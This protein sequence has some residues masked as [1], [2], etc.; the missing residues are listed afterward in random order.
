MLRRKERLMYEELTELENEIIKAIDKVRANRDVPVAVVVGVL[1]T[2]KG[3]TL[4][5]AIRPAET[6]P[7][8]STMQIQDDSGPGMTMVEKNLEPG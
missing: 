3:I 8:D 7:A 1:E 2:V 6:L 4:D 5:N